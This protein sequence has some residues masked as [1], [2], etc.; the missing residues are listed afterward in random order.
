MPTTRRPG[1]QAGSFIDSSGR[2][3]RPSPFKETPPLRSACYCVVEALKQGREKTLGGRPGAKERKNFLRSSGKIESFPSFPS[4]LLC[5]LSFAQHSQPVAEAICHRPPSSFPSSLLLENLYLMPFAVTFLFL[6]HLT[7][8]RLLG[9]LL[10]AFLACSKSEVTTSETV[11]GPLLFPFPF[12][13]LFYPLL[14]QFATVG[15]FS[16][17]SC[18]LRW[19]RI[20]PFS[21]FA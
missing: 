16:F 8:A 7:L 3:E 11:K 2:S 10:C 6:L 17:R 13:L 19:A 21:F 12:L 1:R 9:A 15:H 20:S 5:L 14:R 4:A 18:R